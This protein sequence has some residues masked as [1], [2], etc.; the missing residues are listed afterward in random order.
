[1]SGVIFQAISDTAPCCD[2]YAYYVN[3]GCYGGFNNPIF[4][5]VIVRPSRLKNALSKSH[6]INISTALDVD[7]G[8][9]SD[10]L[11]HSTVFRPTCHSIDVISRSVLLPNMSTGN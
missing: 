7:D 3:S 9:K 1:M 5:H 6:K 4:D 10:D 2:D 8:K 11:Y